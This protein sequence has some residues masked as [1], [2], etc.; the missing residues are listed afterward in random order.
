MPCIEACP[1]GALSNVESHPVTPV[2]KVTLHLDEC[3]TS[4]GVLCDT[5]SVFCPDDVQAIRMVNC[6]PVLDRESCVGCGL[7]VY[8]CE[9]DKQPLRIEDLADPY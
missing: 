5:C 4:E 3:L 9:S 7:C 8:Y 6:S 1:S 2:A